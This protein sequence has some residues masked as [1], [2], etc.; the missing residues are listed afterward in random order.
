M[1]M[2]DLPDDFALLAGDD[3]LLRS[4]RSAHGR[5]SYLRP[6]ARR[7]RRLRRRLARGGGRAGRELGNR[8]AA[9]AAALFADPT[10]VIKGC[11]RPGQDPEPGGAAAAV[12][13]RDDTVHAA[14]SLLGPRPAPQRQVPVPG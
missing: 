5:H 6:G 3:V 4:S 7:E 13:A 14:L 1:L 2:A 10:V 12:R 11:S 8:L 9:L